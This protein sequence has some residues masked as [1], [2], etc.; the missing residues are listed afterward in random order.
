ML[1]LFCILFLNICC[2]MYYV[3]CKQTCVSVWCVNFCLETSLS[4]WVYNLWSI[5]IDSKGTLHESVCK[6]KIEFGQEKFRLAALS[7][8]SYGVIVFVEWTFSGRKFD[9]ICSTMKNSGLL[10]HTECYTQ[11]LPLNF[12]GSNNV[13]SQSVSHHCG[14]PRK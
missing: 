6:I 4:R 13:E 12:L 8:N 9:I 10:R 11:K 14:C 1:Y 7:Q 3:V 5:F 2:H